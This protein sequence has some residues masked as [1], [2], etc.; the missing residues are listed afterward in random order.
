MIQTQSPNSRR[1]AEETAYIAGLY[2]SQSSTKTL[3]TNNNSNS[4]PYAAIA[5]HP[6]QRLL[7]TSNYVKTYQLTSPSV[8]VT[9]LEAGFQYPSG[10]NTFKLQ[11]RSNHTLYLYMVMFALTLF[12]AVPSIVVVYPDF[13]LSICCSMGL[14]LSGMLFGTGSFL[15]LKAGL[16]IWRR[17]FDF[18]RIFFNKGSSFNATTLEKLERDEYHDDIHTVSENYYY[19]LRKGKTTNGNFNYG[20]VIDASVGSLCFTFGK[21]GIDTAIRAFDRLVYGFSADDNSLALL[22]K[23]VLIAV[24]C[25]FCIINQK[26]I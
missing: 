23:L 24:S 18:E 10:H 2:A 7:H 12:V 16:T 15:I 22:L 14:C 25:G 1:K 17:D 9:D 8:D 4:S 6:H 26:V 13:A 20:I 5:S 19:K 21:F 11:I 3:P